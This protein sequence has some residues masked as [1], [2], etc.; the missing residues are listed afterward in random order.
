MANLEQAKE[1]LAKFDF[2]KAADHFALAQANFSQAAGALNLLGANFL[3]AFG[4]IAGLEKVE[5]ANALVKAGQHVAKAGENLALAFSNLARI[6]PFAFADGGRPGNQQSLATLIGDF[7]EVLTFAQDNL[8]RAGELLANV[9]VSALPVDKQQQL[10]NFKEQIPQFQN[11]LAGAVDYSDFLLKIVGQGGPKRYLALFQNNSELRATG[12]F[13]GS[14]A[15]IT[16]DDGYLKNVVVDDIYN[17]DGQLRENIIPP[18]PL[19]HITP[20]WGMRDANWFADFPTSARKIEEMYQRNGGGKVDGVLTITPD[21]VAKIL[22]VVGPV[23]LPEYN[24]KIDSSNFLLE[25]QEEVEYGENRAQPKTIIKDL[26]PKLFAKLGQLDR[27]R[28]PEI[29]K[30]LIGAVERKQILAYF[31]E[32]GLQ[33]VA[34]ASGL[35][36]ELKN[37]VG[38]YLQVVFSNVKGSKSDAFTDNSF[39]LETA[40]SVGGDIAHRLTIS[41]LHRGGDTP[42]G[43]YNRPNT[44]YIRVYAPKGASLESIQGHTLTD[45]RSVIGHQ[46]FGFKTDPELAAIESGA[47]HP[48]S[49]VDVFEESGRTVFGFWLVVKPK[50]TKS[51]VLAY[52]TPLAIDDNRYDLLWQKQAGTGSDPI[53]FSFLVPSGR[54]AA[55]N[56]E[57]LRVAGGKAAWSSDLTIDRNISLEISP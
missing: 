56:S 53:R 13:P 1:N 46:D 8:T 27:G 28:W 21:V 57:G 41:R 39:A 2:S 14:Y 9:S 17:I 26:Q 35:A 38:D 47:S 52:R 16:F 7:R 55:S 20:N 15:L 18:K 6:N 37:P 50:E 45:F 24:L 36:G 49:G 23:D 10:V 5:S 4:G 22:D 43:F 25:I 3:S 11:Y 48:F 44:S 29:F 33:K 30:A 51:A 42:Y 32:S 31:N 12:G 34:V 19:R 40:V 54:Q